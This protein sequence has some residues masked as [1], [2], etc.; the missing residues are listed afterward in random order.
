MTFSSVIKCI[1]QPGCSPAAPASV[2]PDNI[3]IENLIKTMQKL[4]K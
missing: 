3:K 1:P 2:S 4:E